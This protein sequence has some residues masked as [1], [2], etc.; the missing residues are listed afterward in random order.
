MCVVSPYFLCFLV[1]FTRIMTFSALFPCIYQVL[2]WRHLVSYLDTID[3]TQSA[4]YWVNVIL[5]DDKSA[6]C[7]FFDFS[8]HF[9]FRVCLC[10]PT[11]CMMMNNLKIKVQTLISCFKTTKNVLSIF[12]ITSSTQFNSP[13]PIYR[14]IIRFDILSTLI[15]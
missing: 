9:H 7:L 6:F 12:Y 2:M 10:S 3:N 11:Q 8:S 4:I 15:P 14:K 13:L 1:L 5:L